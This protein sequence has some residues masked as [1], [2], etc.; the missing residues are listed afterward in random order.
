MDGGLSR[1][2]RTGFNDPKIVEVI[3]DELR[4]SIDMRDHDRRR[5]IAIT[6]IA[7]AIAL[8][9]IN[10]RAKMEELLNT[11]LL[12]TEMSKKELS[13]RLEAIR[14]EVALPEEDRK[15][16]LWIRKYLER[17]SKTQT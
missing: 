4:R 5:A 12:K 10:M 9:Q 14:K 11:L 8:N 15:N 16:L 6:E 13:D 1:R 2:F 7:R 3:F 17:A